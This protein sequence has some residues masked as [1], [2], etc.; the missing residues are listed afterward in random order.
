MHV[1]RGACRHIRL[2]LGE[3]RLKIILVHAYG[4]NFARPR[5]STSS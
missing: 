4:L 1:R 3:K 5:L 2:E